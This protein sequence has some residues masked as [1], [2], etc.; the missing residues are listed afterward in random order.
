MNSETTPPRLL[1]IDAVRVLAIVLM[2]YFHLAF[3]LNV[4]NFVD[5]DFI[6]DPFWWFLP[7]LIVA[8][9]LLAVGASMAVVDQRQELSAKRV[10]KRFFKLAFL[11]LVISVF[12]YFAF[13]STWIY[14][15][16]LHCIALC[17]LLAWPLLLLGPKKRMPLSLLITLILWL[18]VF[19][20][21]FIWPWIQLD[22]ASMDYIPVLPWFG[23]VSLGIALYD[24]RFFHACDP[25]LRPLAKFKLYSVVTWMGR[26]SLKIYLLHQPLLYGLVWLTYILVK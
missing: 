22:H 2:I 10:L 12:T 7:R 18:P 13:P 3:D 21:N 26:H 24:L 17:S 1:A 19:T 14:F 15:G 16:T 4:F 20:H 6:A 11:A 8:L 5:I 25:L 23:L 9:F